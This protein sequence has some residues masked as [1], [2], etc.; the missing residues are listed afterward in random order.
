META[1]F[2][3]LIPDLCTGCGH[4][5]R[6][7]PAAVLALSEGVAIVCGP[8]CIRCGHC[9]AVCPVQAVVVKGIRTGLG[10]ESFQEN[11]AWLRWGDFSVVDLVR[12]MRSR[13]SCRNYTDEAVPRPWLAD[14]VK[15]GTTAPSGS[16]SQKWTFTVLATRKEVEVLG[17]G[18]A[19]FFKRLNRLAANRFARMYSRLF[20]GDALGRYFRRHYETV[21]RGVRAWEEEGRDVLFHGAPT[22]IIIGSAPGGSCP[23]E[24]AL[25]AAQNIL[26]AAHAMGLGTCMIGYAVAALNRDAGLKRLVAIPVTEAVQAVIVLG[27]PD[28]EYHHLAGRKAVTP[29][30]PAIAGH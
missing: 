28:V 19:M 2:P 18:I 21:W 20:G 24:D 11:E 10:F 5:V 22:T 14:L 1:I 8:G 25:M 13:R 6:V 7:C 3:T 12:L 15:I 26:L 30:F 23:Q 27:F 16:N 9:L 29:R 4:C 17:A